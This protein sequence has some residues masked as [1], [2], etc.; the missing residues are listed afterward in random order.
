MIVIE[1]SELCLWTDELRRRFVQQ[2]PTNSKPTG[3]VRKFAETT[4][5]RPMPIWQFE[6]VSRFSCWKLV[7][8]CGKLVNC[9]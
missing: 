6:G 8:S 5:K 1:Q 4:K 2:P 3:S 9:V 7:R